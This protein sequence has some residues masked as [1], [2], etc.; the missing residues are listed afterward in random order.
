MRHDLQL[1]LALSSD[2]NALK[3]RR[4]AVMVYRE[5]RWF[6]VGLETKEHCRTVQDV[7][8]NHAHKDLGSF[9]FL[10]SAYLAGRRF[11]REAPEVLNL[12]AC[13]DLS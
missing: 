12:C 4:A 8:D 9:R 1:G 11:V 7:L 13:E 2:A 6:C 5:G 3:V 10:A